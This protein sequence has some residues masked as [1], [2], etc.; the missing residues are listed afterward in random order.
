MGHGCL[1]PGCLGSSATCP[2][3]T[4]S[5]SKLLLTCT[6]ASKIIGQQ[7][8]SKACFIVTWKFLNQFYFIVTATMGVQLWRP[9]LHLPMTLPKLGDQAHIQAPAHVGFANSLQ[10][11]QKTAHRLGCYSPS[12]RGRS[13]DPSFVQLHQAYRPRH[14]LK[15][16]IWARI[17]RVTITCRRYKKSARRLSAL[18]QSQDM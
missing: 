5:S 16:A 12:G 8:W 18:L 13:Q 7:S 14:P 11:C 17:C 4:K 6:H 10:Q 1:L 15:A 2:A 3:T 9:A